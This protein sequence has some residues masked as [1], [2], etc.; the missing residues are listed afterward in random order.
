MGGLW[1]KW[2]A[3]EKARAPTVRQKKGAGRHRGSCLAR[4]Q[5]G[6]GGEKQMTELQVSSVTGMRG[7][8]EICGFLGD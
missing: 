5:R 3:Q 1:E 8:L 4:A 2:C 7:G 6:G